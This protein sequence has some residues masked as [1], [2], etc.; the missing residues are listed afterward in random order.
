MLFRSNV[1]AEPKQTAQSAIDALVRQI[2]SPVQWQDCVFR[3]ASVG[4]TTYV[5]V[6]PGRVLA[7][8]VRKI[9]RDA[10]IFSFAEPGD[11]DSIH[12]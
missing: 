4:V 2:A 9:R 11:L 1:D 10:T 12:V 3:L 7:G 6:G 5:E 8:L